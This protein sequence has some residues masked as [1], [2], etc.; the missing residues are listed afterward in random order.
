MVIGIVRTIGMVFCGD[1][2]HGHPIIKHISF[3]WTLKNS[4]N[5]SQLFFLGKIF[6]DS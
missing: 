3:Q 6:I 1:I 4:Y 5:I 2:T